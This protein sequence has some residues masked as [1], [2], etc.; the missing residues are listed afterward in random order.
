MGVLVLQAAIPN[1]PASGDKRLKD[2]MSAEVSNA[3]RSGGGGSVF[4]IATAGVICGF[5]AIVLSIGHGGLL[6]AGSQQQFIPIAIGLALFSTVVLATVAALFSST[7]GAV[8][9]TQEIPVVALAAVVAA[10]GN[11]LPSGVDDSTRLA[12]VIVASAIATAITGL[13]AVLLGYYRL[14]SIIRFVPYPVIGGFLAGTGWLIVSGGFSL[15][16]GMPLDLTAR[17]FTDNS[18]EVAK[19]GA[20][21]LVVCA[22][23]AAQ[24]RSS[25]NFALPAT[26]LAAL[27]VF[28]LAATALGQNSA[29]LRAEGWLLRLPENGTLWPPLAITDLT[30]VDWRS[31]AAGVAGIPAVVVLTI[32]ALLMNATGIELDSQQDVDLDHEL[33]AIGAMNVATAAG[34]GLPGYQAVSLTLLATRLGAASRWV[35]LVVAALTLAALAFREVLFDV[36]PTV[37]L[38]SVL[39]WIGGDLIVTWLLRSYRRIGF[40]EYL[41]IVLIFLTIVG[42]SFLAG[43]IVGLAAAIIL[44]AIQYGRVDVI[45]HE[46]SGTDYQSSVESSEHRRALLLDHGAAIFI[47]RLQGFLFFGTADRLRRR[48]QERMTAAEPSPHPFVLIDFQRVTGLDSSTVLSFIRIGQIARR[49]GSVVV[50]T[51]VSEAA[52]AAFIRGGLDDGPG[53]PFRFESDFQRGLKWCEDTLLAGVA[54]DFANTRSR[55]LAVLL[56]TVVDDAETA[57]AIASFC[58]RVDADPGTLLIEQGSPSEDIFFVESGQAAVEMTTIEGETLRLTSVGGGA[59][60]GEVAFYTGEPRTASVVVEETMVAWRFSREDLRRLETS[61]PQTALRFHEGIAA[62]LGRRL[63]RTN[64]LVQSLAG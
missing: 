16:T 61:A 1:M 5:L 52:R 11:A 10:V 43:I 51:Q 55:H 18:T 59:V 29:S 50:L 34:A 15:V 64:R 42:V 54:P 46:M 57:A 40:W 27:I 56:E 17:A 24:W 3:A 12:T 58:Q 33:R 48:V 21:A 49:A 45:R 7:K 41:V 25:S 19:V 63:T 14:G 13:V 8:A 4:T 23:I 26:I 53:S 60:V 20:M 62:M 36:V 9:I 32:I 2:H 47:V 22:L 30:L 38:G 37:L 31:V 35:G 39:V 28:H 6:F 44:F